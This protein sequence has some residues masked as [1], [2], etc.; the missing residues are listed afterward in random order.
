VFLPA[1]DEILCGEFSMAMMKG[2]VTTLQSVLGKTDYE[3]EDSLGYRHG[4]L[5]PGF[6]IYTLAQTVN[7]GEFVWRDKT[8]YSAGW[9]RDPSIKFGDDPNVVWG[10]QRQDELRAAL[11]RKL[12]YDEKAVDLEIDKLRQRDVLELNMRTGPRKIVKVRPLKKLGPDDYPDSI[13][14]NIPQWEL[15]VPKQFSLVGKFHGTAP[16]SL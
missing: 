4:S 7:A 16:Y 3:L 5:K 14:G 10:V 12:N 1:Q 2:Y 6:E 8:R 11:G 9:H 13:A 15:T